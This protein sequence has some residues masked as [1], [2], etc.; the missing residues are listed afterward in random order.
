MITTIEYG[1][2]EIVLEEYLKKR[3]ISKNTIAEKANLQR[4]QLNSYCK[5]KIKRPD[6]DVLARICFALNCEL[7][8]IIR[9]VKPINSLGENEDGR[10]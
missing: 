7:S 1:Y 10:K 5:N 2:F 4:T 9:Y 3:N 6:F 8:D